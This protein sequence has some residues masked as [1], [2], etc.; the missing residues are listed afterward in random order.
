MK[1]RRIGVTTAYTSPRRKYN[2]IRGSVV[3]KSKLPGSMACSRSCS[4]L[5]KKA[6]F[7]WNMTSG[8]NLRT[9]AATPAH[10]STI[11][12]VMKNV[13]FMGIDSPTVSGILV[14]TEGEEMTKHL[15][16]SKY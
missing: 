16:G 3:P 12:Y 5:T 6:F 13:A 11:K 2:C 14:A 10:P 15:D 1:G 7:I 4:V 9:S 8:F